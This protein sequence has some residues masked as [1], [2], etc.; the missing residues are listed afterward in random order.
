MEYK[1]K[2]A[3]QLVCEP[4]V[5]LYVSHLLPAREN[6]TNSHFATPLAQTEIRGA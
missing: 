2:I 6:K 1:L 4:E 5:L 3:A